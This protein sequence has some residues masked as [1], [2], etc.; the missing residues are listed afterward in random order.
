V[1]Y[2]RE[3]EGKIKKALQNAKRRMP[4]S[5]APPPD[6]VPC[7][8]TILKH[9]QLVVSLIEGRPVSRQEIL[10]MLARGLRQ[11]SMVRRRRIDQALDWLK[12]NPP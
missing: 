10:E 4:V 9:V 6:P 1:A 12:A 3:P 2:Y 5:P 11:H 7:P 8:E